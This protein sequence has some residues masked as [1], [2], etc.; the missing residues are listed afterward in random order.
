MTYVPLIG[1][2]FLCEVKSKIDSGRLE[3]D[4]TKLRKVSKLAKSEQRTFAI[5]QTGTYTT[6]SQ[7]KCLVYDE[8]S[9][10]DERLVDQLIEY[11][12]AWDLLL[13]VQDDVLFV[14]SSLPFFDDM[15]GPADVVSDEFDIDE[16]SFD[17]SIIEDDSE[18]DSE[19]V[20]KMK[21]DLKMSIRKDRNFGTLNNGM[22]WFLLLLSASIPR[23]LGI[24]TADTLKNL[25]EKYQDLTAQNTAQK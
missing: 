3:K 12:D 1:T 22:A 16:I 4:L 10:S 14:N 9:I 18:I 8:R 7:I 21:S 23:P 5:S 17:D 24:D 20:A 25:I 2:A 19:Q 6:N 11:Q 13:I 15:R